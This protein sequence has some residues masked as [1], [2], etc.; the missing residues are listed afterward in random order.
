MSF[1]RSIQQ[2]PLDSRMPRNEQD[3]QEAPPQVNRAVNNSW[4]EKKR[5]SSLDEVLHPLN[6]Q[7]EI[8]GAAWKL[9]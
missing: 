2:F 3:K 1:M 9:L 7:E 8:V 6:C 5:A 4:R